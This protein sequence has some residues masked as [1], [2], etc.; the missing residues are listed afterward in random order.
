MS[1][2]KLVFVA[3]KRTPFGSFGGSLKDLS[4]TEMAVEASRACL[5]QARIDAKAIDSVVVGNV[6]QSDRDSIYLAR[7]V[8]LKLGVPLSHSSLTVNRLCGSGF[9]AIAQGA[10][11]ILC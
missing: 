8:G 5:N 7:H 11:R 6:C 4:A 2:K 9:E 3:A 1:L 10:Y